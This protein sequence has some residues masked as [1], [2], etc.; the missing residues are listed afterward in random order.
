MSGENYNVVGEEQTRR[1]LA[2]LLLK[3]TGGIISLTL[4][5]CFILIWNGKLEVEKAVTLVLA[6]ST[7]FSGLLAS[8]ITYYF[9][10]K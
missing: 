6:V 1:E 9:S 8:A 7:I 10:T 5:G 4:L 3:W 2:T